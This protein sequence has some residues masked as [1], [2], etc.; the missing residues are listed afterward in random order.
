MSL[1]EIKLPDGS[2]RE[3]ETEINGFQVAKSISPSLAK[4]AVAIKIDGVV[5][6]LS[7][8]IPSGSPVEILTFDNAEGKE[9]FWHSSSHIMAQAVLELFPDSKLAIGPPI[10]EGWYYDFEV[11]KPFTPEDLEKIEKQMAVIVKENAPFKCEVKN[12]LESIKYF[13]SKDAP[14]KVELL[15]G[16]EGETVTFYYQ[17]TFEDLCKGPHIPKTGI[18]KA[19]KLTATSGAYWRGDEKNMMLQRIY[20]VSYPKKEMLEEF[21]YRMEE[22]K[23]RDHR[24][25]GKKLELFI[26]SDE[27]GPGLIMWMPK[28]ARIR[29]EIENFWRNEHFKYDYDLVVSPHIA[30]RGLWE[31]SGHTDFYSDNMYGPMEVDK[32]LYQLKPMNCPFHIMMYKSKMWSY[33]DLPLRWAE[34]GTVYRYERAGTLHGLMRVRGLTQDDAHHFVAQDKMEEELVWILKFCVH[35]LKSFGFIDYE[36]F[37]STRPEKAI[38]EQEDWD[39]AEQGLKDALKLAN[40]DYQIDE[41]GGAFYG[42]KIDIKIKD[43]LNRSWQ[44]STIQ[45]DFSLPE[46]FDLHYID[47]DGKQRRPFMI[48]RALLGSIERFF[49]V[50]IEHYAGNFPLWLAPVQVKILP[51]TDSI[52]EYGEEILKILKSKNIRAEIDSR[53]EKVGAKIRD[54]EI[55]KV[56]YMFVV[57]GKEAEAKT[58]SIRKHTAGDI[59]VKTIDDAIR[60]L[61]TEIESKGLN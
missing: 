32:G 19:I 1:V 9:V 59:G 4:A 17:S 38:G 48:H 33:R 43:A 24:L 34:L 36:I 52:I 28:G 53:S 50:L 2:I 7:A 31:K 45:F 46:R 12:R 47:S 60:D 49:G 37:M 58:V 26:L 3:F 40:L 11:S 56:P 20:G 23:K 55:M 51:I 25:I 14:Y 61:E 22:A 29:N 35:I 15:E 44:C 30:H 39:R 21:V 27:V 54:A 6:D 42:P 16:L 13:K 10:A 18:V 57:G 8:M 41:G 5:S